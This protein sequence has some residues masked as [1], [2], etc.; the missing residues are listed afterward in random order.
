MREIGAL[1]DNLIS[2]IFQC[3]FPIRRMDKLQ[4]NFLITGEYFKT[5]FCKHTEHL[6][7]DF[8][9]GGGKNYIRAGYPFFIT[10][11]TAFSIAISRENPQIFRLRRGNPL[12]LTG[13]NYLHFS[14]CGKKCRED[15][16][17][18]GGVSRLLW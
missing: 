8:Y 9:A 3:I 13:K 6:Q 7:L 2:R 5:N 11:Y 4:I 12:S 18:P 15:P 16:P 14:A 1:L 17:T 10:K